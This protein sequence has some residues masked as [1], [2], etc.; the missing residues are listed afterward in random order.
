M[1]DVFQGSAREDA[2]SANLQVFAEDH[3]E[4]G[5][6][7]AECKDPAAE[8]QVVCIR[9]EH[10]VIYNVVDKSTTN[11]NRTLKMFSLFRHFEEGLLHAF[12]ACLGLN[13]MTVMR[14]WWS[15]ATCCY[16]SCLTN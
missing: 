12:T 2:E 6:I 7:Q 13:I 4:F 9:G 8:N 14:P 15:G 3:N 1:C 11:N 16:C 5:W 10:Q